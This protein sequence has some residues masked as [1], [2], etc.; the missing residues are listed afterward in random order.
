MRCDGSSLLPTFATGSTC[1]GHYTPTSR[2]DRHCSL[3][4]PIQLAR[5]PEPTRVAQARRPIRPIPP[6][7]SVRL[8]A[9]QTHFGG[10]RSA[11]ISASRDLLAKLT[12]RRIADMR[13]SNRHGNS[14]HTA[15]LHSL[16]WTQTRAGPSSDWPWSGAG[17]L[18]ASNR[19]WY[20]GGCGWS[21]F[22]RSRS[23][24]WT[25]CRVGGSDMASNMMN[26]FDQ[27]PMCHGLTCLRGRC[28]AHGAC[29]IHPQ[30]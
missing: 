1:L 20:G 21:V 12:R 11:P 29:G 24:L 8:S 7:H 25:G 30:R 23:L 15:L 6:L 10:P 9:M 14:V 28:P 27:W 4:Q 5:I 2:R 3:P 17:R 19:G 26:S 13:F 18:G 16:R 22:A